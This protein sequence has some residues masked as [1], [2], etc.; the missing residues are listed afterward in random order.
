MGDA[1]AR[2]HAIVAVLRRDGQILVIRRGGQASRAGYW[3][4]LSGRIEPGESQ[5]AAVVRE[6]REEVGL[7]ATP[8]AKVW[9]C[10]TDD[11]EF[12]LHWWTAEA[13]P[14][15]LVLDRTEVGDARWV[16]VEEFLRLEPTFAG[17]REFFVQV[18]PRLSW[19]NGSTGPPSD[20]SPGAT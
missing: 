12:L 20:G 6:I 5:P 19:P 18:F 2:Q 8:I 1:D 4:P 3:A 16:T 14:G 7:E 17:D 15:P 10:D 13:A 9:E 11:G